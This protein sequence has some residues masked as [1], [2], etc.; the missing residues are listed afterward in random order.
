MDHY[1]QGVEEFCYCIAPVVTKEKSHSIYASHPYATL[2]QTKPRS[3]IFERIDY[4]YVLNI[5]KI[6]CEKTKNRLEEDDLALCLQI[7]T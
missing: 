6:E 2:D 3:S 1:I 7:V 4:K 5:L